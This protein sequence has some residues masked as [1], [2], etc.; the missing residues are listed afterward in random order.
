MVI[1]ATQTSHYP[2]RRHEAG[3]RAEKCYTNKD[4]ISK[5][6]NKDNPLVNNQLSNTVDYFLLWQNYDNDKT[7]F[8]KPQSNCKGTLK[9][10]LMELGALMSHLVAAKTAQHTTPG[11]PKLHGTCATKTF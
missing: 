11:T 6:Y 9:M 8:L 5:S 1:V 10:Y 4:S 2:E 3:N 7:R